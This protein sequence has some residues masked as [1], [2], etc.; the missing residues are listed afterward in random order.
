M[1]RNLKLRGVFGV[2]HGDQ[3]ETVCEFGQ[4]KKIGPHRAKWTAIQGKR[5]ETVPTRP[6]SSSNIV[7]NGWSSVS[8]ALKSHYDQDA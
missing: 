8:I 4:N 3:L 6:E 1:S 5:V 2:G 7:A